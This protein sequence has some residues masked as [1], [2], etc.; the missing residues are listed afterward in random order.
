MSVRVHTSVTFSFFLFS[1]SFLLLLLYV[2]LVVNKHD[3]I[4]SLVHVH[5]EVIL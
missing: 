4:Y 1:I 2:T 5:G 3:I